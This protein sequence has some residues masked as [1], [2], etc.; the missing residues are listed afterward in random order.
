MILFCCTFEP[1]LSGDLSVMEVVY[2]YYYIFF[3]QMT[4]VAG[5][6][7]PHSITR[8]TLA[9]PTTDFAR[10]CCYVMIGRGLTSRE[11]LIGCDGYNL[12]PAGKI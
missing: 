8:Q 4:V 6:K 3:V 1:G 5:S 12:S 10:C 7:V 11:S 9:P 2:Y